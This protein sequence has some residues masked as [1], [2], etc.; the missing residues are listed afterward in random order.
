MQED[1]AAIQRDLGWLEKWPVRKFMKFGKDKR[2]KIKQVQHLGRKGPLQQ[3]RLGT[4]GLG[5]TFVGKD[6]GSWWPQ[7]SSV[8][9]KQ[10]RPRASRNRASR[11]GKGIIC[12]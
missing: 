7:A 1:R 3:Y 5:S 11:P 4:G 12:I 9:W 8:S 6:M 10:R 2:E